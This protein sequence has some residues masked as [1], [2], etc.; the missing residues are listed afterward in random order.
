[1][2]I[3]RITDRLGRDFSAVIECE[4][5]GHEQVLK[6]GYNDSYYHDRVIPAMKCAACGKR[7]REIVSEIAAESQEKGGA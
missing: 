1:M 7:A 2:I 6:T 3:K 5:C 4:H